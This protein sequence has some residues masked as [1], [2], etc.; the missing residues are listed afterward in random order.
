MLSCLWFAKKSFGIS[1]FLPEL[2]GRQTELSCA[3]SSPSTTLFPWTSQMEH[4]IP[5]TFILFIWKQRQICKSYRSH[6]DVFMW[7][8]V[9]FGLCVF[10][11]LQEYPHHPA[12]GLLTP[13][14]SL[15]K[16]TSH[17]T[18]LLIATAITAL[19]VF[20]ICQDKNNHSALSKH[21]I[22]WSGQQSCDFTSTEVRI[23]LQGQHC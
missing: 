11:F 20:P 6:S 1:V 10:L 13:H 19:F 4:I 8:K 23:C 5:C 12:L 21:G 7:K 16:A 3:W 22:S 2:L 14:S 17:S 9:W 18:V 15:S